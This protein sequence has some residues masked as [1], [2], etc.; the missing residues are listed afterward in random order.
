[1]INKFQILRILMKVPDL[2]NHPQIFTLITCLGGVFYGFCLGEFAQILPYNTNWHFSQDLKNINYSLF[3]SLYP[4]GS[5]VGNLISGYTAY[6]F[7]R[8]KTIIF[9]DIITLIALMIMIFCD[10]FEAFFIGRFFMGISTGVNFP[11]MLLI[12]REFILAEDYL[13]CIIYFQITNT[14]GIFIANLLC[15]SNK[16][17]LPITISL[18]F[19]LIRMIY[20]VFLMRNKIDTPL[21]M[22]NSI[23][24]EDINK[25]ESN[26]ILEKLYPGMNIDIL[27]DNIKLKET[28]L[29]KE[30]FLGSVFGPGFL[31]ESMFCIAILFLNQASG[32]N[33]ILGYSG[34]FF[35]DHGTTISIIFSFMNMIGGLSNII[36]I[37]HYNVN[38][39]MRYF[40]GVTFHKGFK[41]F[42]IGTIFIIILLGIFGFF[43]DFSPN[44]EYK[45]EFAVVFIVLG[46]IYLLYFQYCIAIYP[47]IYIPVILPDIGVFMV[48]F[49][50]SI[51]SMITSLSFYF[52]TNKSNI[53]TVIF[54]FC[55]VT[56]IIGII[57]AVFLY[58]KYLR[59]KVL[60]VD[61]KENFYVD[62][63]EKESMISKENSRILELK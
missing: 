34:L 32:I 42:V 4:S 16:W 6:K 55:F 57:I 3:N 51:F 7:G 12:I 28:L 14:I 27:Q 5:F 15:L 33:Q 23:K 2:V 26:K 36:A 19:P 45:N 9:T 22:L 61:I 48:I 58:A 60:E 41:R 18:L 47:F 11:M 49:I 54:R 13:R 25:E 31:A 44:H 29:K 39:F 30:F 59:K 1:M 56:S 37:P 8:V 40:M 43:I 21:F 35:K 17:R 50:H 46:S 52:G 38:N 53:F 24:E 20:Y 10:N 62:L 63:K